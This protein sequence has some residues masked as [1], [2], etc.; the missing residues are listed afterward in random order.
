MLKF[1]LRTEVLNAGFIASVPSRTLS[2]NLYSARL[3]VVKSPTSTSAVTSV[4]P[5]ARRLEAFFGTSTRKDYNVTRSVLGK[6]PR[7]NMVGSYIS[8]SHLH[9]SI[10]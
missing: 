5:Q 10:G 8:S 3:S 6:N 1:P 2:L 9:G 7:R 4:P